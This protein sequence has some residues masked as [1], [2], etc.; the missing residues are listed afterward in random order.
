MVE[1]MLFDLYWV[2]DNLMTKDVGRKLHI[3]S[4]GLNRF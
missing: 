2:D 3:L 1:R 4:L